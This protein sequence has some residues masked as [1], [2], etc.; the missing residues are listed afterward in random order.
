M[1]R[2]PK[3]M[4]HFWI[5]LETPIRSLKSHSTPS[6]CQEVSAEIPAKLARRSATGL[7]GHFAG[8]SDGLL[9]GIVERYWSAALGWRPQIAGY[10]RVWK[11]TT[12][13]CAGRDPTAGRPA[14]LTL[15]PLAPAAARSRALAG[16]GPRPSLV[17]RLQHSAKWE[18]KVSAGPRLGQLCSYLCCGLRYIVGGVIFIIDPVGCNWQRL[19]LFRLLH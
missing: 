16:M 9:R 6:G 7:A 13:T 2:L 12:P 3:L 4:G 15:D 1:L 8:V 5:L 17:S 18:D 14:K 19:S 10:R 11:H